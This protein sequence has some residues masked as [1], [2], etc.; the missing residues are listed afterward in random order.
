[1]A[2]SQRW[3]EC[4]LTLNKYKQKKKLHVATSKSQSTRQTYAK[5]EN[6]IVKWLTLCQLLFKEENKLKIH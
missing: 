2:C 4:F 6:L 3:L 1:M 5:I